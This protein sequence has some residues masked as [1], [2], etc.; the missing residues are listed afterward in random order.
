M[1]KNYEDGK[2]VEE[3]V[4]LNMNTFDMIKFF[5]KNAIP[6]TNYDIPIIV[7]EEKMKKYPYP[8]NNQFS[9]GYELPL[10]SKSIFDF[11]EFIDKN[12]ISLK[13]NQIDNS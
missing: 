5:F 2:M 7:D 1:L 6:H 8:T 3:N 13:H 10:I 4:V 11:Y 12:E 9:V